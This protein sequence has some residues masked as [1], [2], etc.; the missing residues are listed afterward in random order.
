MSKL[1]RSRGAGETDA[2]GG[3][4]SGRVKQPG[5]KRRKTGGGEGRGAGTERSDVDSAVKDALSQR[6]K[7][8]SDP[9]TIRR[10]WIVYSINSV[11]T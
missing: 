2:R 10:W 4:D 9:T 3:G 8:V 7:G 5:A 1:K 11:G 6:H